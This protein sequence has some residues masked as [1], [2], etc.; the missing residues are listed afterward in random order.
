MN[1]YQ[2]IE[3]EDCTPR[4]HPY[5]SLGFPEPVRK[6]WYLTD[7]HDEE[8]E[9]TTYFI[10]VPGNSLAIAMLQNWLIQRQDEKYSYG[11]TTTPREAVES[12]L[13]YMG[14][15]PTLIYLEGRLNIHA[16]EEAVAS[17]E[18]FLAEG[19]LVRLLSN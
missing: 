2:Y 14:M 6:Y 18:D 7:R 13:A 17:R 4:S 12:I 5:I 19:G 15:N 1:E 8:G 9:G 10:E 11:Y 3:M 16:I